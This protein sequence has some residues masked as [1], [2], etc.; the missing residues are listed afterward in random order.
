MRC[1]D[2]KTWCA[3][4][5]RGC[6]APGRQIARLLKMSPNTERKY[7]LALEA[8]GLLVG[9]PDELPSCEFLKNVMEEAMPPTSYPQ[10]ISSIEAFKEDISKMLTRGAGPKAIYDRLRLEREDF[11]AGLSAVKRMCI[12]IKKERGPDARD[13]VLVVETDPGKI[14][15]VDFGYV[16]QLFDP[17][18]GKVRK[19]YA[20]IMVL[21]YSRKMYA[22][23]V[24]DQSSETWLEQHIRAFEYFGGV[25]ETVVPDNLKAAVIRCHFVFSEKPD[26]NR[27][28][29]ELA[30]SYGFFIDPTPPYAPQ[31]K[32]KVE[33]AV[34]YLQQNF[35]LPRSLSELEEA[36]IQLRQWLDE[37]ANKR[38]HGTTGK[39]P[40]DVFEEVEL[41]TLRELPAERFRPTIWKKAKVHPDSHV[42]FERRLYSV[43]FV[44]VGKEAFV[45]AS[46]QSV[47][48]FIE[49]VRVATHSRR[50]PR[51]S[52]NDA[53]LPEGRRDLHHRSREWWQDR[54]DGLGVEVG[55]YIEEVFLADDVFNQLRVVQAIVSHLE[56]FPPERAEAACRR[57][58]AFGAYN[59][60]AIRR[61]LV[62][63]LDMEPIT[64]QT[65]YVHGKLEEPRFARSMSEMMEINHGR[66]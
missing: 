53:H 13:I 16:G 2:Y 38:T 58:R 10:Q 35:F 18:T 24:F 26:L 41:E 49:D 29:R 37:I 64:P 56:K 31:K 46:G 59:Y 65:D 17:D 8:K 23:L 5:E 45:R 47:D 55:E 39:I 25:P 6:R 20:F 60:Q 42:E 50:G 44:H 27:S 62:E 3:C 54:A 52:T 34:N 12:R 9:D 21:G 19:V 11:D 36:R 51:Y 14:A 1:I 33:S 30:R 57:A 15:Q 7:R 48:V 43:P 40:Q 4:T 63:G 28:Y 32:G 22:D 61:I 66:R